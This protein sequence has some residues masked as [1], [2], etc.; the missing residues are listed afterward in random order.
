LSCT[1]SL[2]KATRLADPHPSPTP[3]EIR[4]TV[5]REGIQRRP[6]LPRRGRRIQVAVDIKHRPSAYITKSLR[7]PQQSPPAM[8]IAAGNDRPRQMAMT[9]KTG[10]E[11]GFTGRPA[12]IFGPFSR[13]PEARSV[14]DY[15]SEMN[16][17]ESSIDRTSGKKCSNPPADPEKVTLYARPSCTM[18]V[19]SQVTLVPP[20]V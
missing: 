8:S 20:G 6:L 18:R 12:L 5:N 9:G 19:T 13:G 7:D 2:S 3:H 15:P 16:S 10:T 17:N 14:S 4:T 1:V 11:S